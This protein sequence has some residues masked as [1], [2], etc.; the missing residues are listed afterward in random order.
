MGEC[1][2]ERLE[3]AAGGCPPARGSAPLLPGGVPGAVG[4]GEGTAAPASAGSLISP[5]RLLG[6][7]CQNHTRGGGGWVGG[8]RPPAKGSSDM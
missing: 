7:S 1:F 5:L 8:P 3:A 6:G 4:V 2:G